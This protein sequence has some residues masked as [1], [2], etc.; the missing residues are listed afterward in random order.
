MELDE[1]KRIWA[2][3]SQQLEKQKLLTDKLIL[4]MI[5]EKYQ[6]RFRAMAT[7]ETIGSAIC[8]IAA[9]VFLCNFEKYD[10]WYLV[11][12]AVFTVSYLLLIP[13]FALRSIYRMQNID[14]SSKNYRETMINFTRLRK[15]FDIVTKMG[16]G[17]NFVLL[18]TVMLL[19][20]RVS[21]DDNLL[22]KS[23][24][25]VWLFPAGV[26]FLI[27]FSRWGYRCYSNVTASA[28]NILRELEREKVTE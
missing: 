15:Q 26:I 27:L 17:L 14:V 18:F 16:I 22:E 21:S 20:I 6:N 3:M 7:R 8:V 19:T 2:E 13:F 24:V 9:I 28:E 10:T 25:W 12:S 4:D 1:M 5:R 11:V 23:R